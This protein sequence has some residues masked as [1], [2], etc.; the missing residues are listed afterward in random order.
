MS[1][2]LQFKAGDRVRHASFGGGVVIS[3][4]RVGDDEEVE[5]AFVGKGVKRLM[6]SIAG[7]KKN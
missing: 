3:S 6:A 4:K 5:V 1:N 7:L 2:T